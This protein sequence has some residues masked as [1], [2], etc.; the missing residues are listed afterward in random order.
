M[1][2]LEHMAARAPIFDEALLL[3]S[4]ERAELAARLLESLQ[5]EDPG[6]SEAW[7]SEIRARVRGVAA[8]EAVGSQWAEV[9]ERIL[10]R[11]RRP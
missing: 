10:R 1:R 6:L 4:D 7:E 3:P 11:V 5:P 9:R 8:G 2:Y